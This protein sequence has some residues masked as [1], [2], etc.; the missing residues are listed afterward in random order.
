MRIRNDYVPRAQARR[1]NAATALCPNCKQQ[2][3]FNE[4]EQHMKS[5]FHHL[6]LSDFCADFH[7]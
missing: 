2:I 5:K 1:Q 6:N 4:L 3:P 7:S